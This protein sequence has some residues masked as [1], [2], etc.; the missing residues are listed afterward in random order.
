MTEIMATLLSDVNQFT[1]KFNLFLDGNSF[2]IAS[3]IGEYFPPKLA[4]SAGTQ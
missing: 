4:E 3:T 1:A 2:I